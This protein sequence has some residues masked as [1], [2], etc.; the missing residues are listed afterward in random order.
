MTI[1]LDALA[2]WSAVTRPR[3]RTADADPR[4]PHR[5]GARCRPVRWRAGRHP[6]HRSGEGGV[7]IRQSLS[8]RHR[9]RRIRRRRRRALCLYARRLEG[10]GGPLRFKGARR[11]RR[12]RRCRAARRWTFGTDPSR[13]SEE[14]LSPD[15]ALGY[16]EVHIEQG[17][18]LE[19]ERLPV[20]IVTAIDGVTR[21]NVE[22]D[23]VA[24]HAG[25]VPMPM[26]KDALTA[27]A[28][29]LLAIEAAGAIAVQSGGDRRQ[30]RSAGIGGEHH[31]RPRA[32][33]PRYP[34]P[35]RS[36]TEQRGRRHQASYRGDRAAPRRDRS[37]P[38]ATKCPRRFATMVV[39]AAGESGRKLWRSS[40]GGC[41]A[42]P[43]TTR[44]RSTRSFRS[45]CC[46]CAAVAASATT[47]P[48][49]HRPTTSISLRACC[50]LF[51]IG[52]HHHDHTAH[53]SR[54]I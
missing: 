45:P 53:Q 34:Q 13:L 22:V 21:G 29:M 35:L 9:S 17:P 2:A 38:S 7:Q 40:R 47:P 30:N 46:S 18:V 3:R 54:T 20:G 19:Q 11:N 42:A 5:H 14:A 50:R 4:L 37:F 31:P 41:R 12:R 15:Q 28:E 44:W 6:R 32:L 25:T 36:G 33:Y 49:M 24:G 51:S 43:A 48:S 1:R 52:L 8:V 26:R 10:A 16:V 39:G 27:A 23:G